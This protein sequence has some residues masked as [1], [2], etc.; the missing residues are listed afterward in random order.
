M[1]MMTE[2]CKISQ[3]IQ[4]SYVIDKKLQV[5]PSAFRRKLLALQNMKLLY[6]FMK[7]L[8]FFGGHFSGSSQPESMQI[9]IHNNCPIIT[10][11]AKSLK[12]GFRLL[13]LKSNHPAYSITPVIRCSDMFVFSAGFVHKVQYPACR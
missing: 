10:V 12:V 11:A 2:N 1:V 13:S 8:H 3:L 7:L 6:F 5:K 9:R 4:K